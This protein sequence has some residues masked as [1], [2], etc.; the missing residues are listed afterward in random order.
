[1]HKHK[2]DWD[3]LRYALKVA[4][5][6]SIA[7]AASAL[8]VNRTTVLRRISKFEQKLDFQLFERH[9]A[10]YALAPGAEQ[11]LS[12]ALEVESTLDEL[13]RQIA[14]KAIQLQGSLRVTTTDS[15]LTGTVAPYIA[16]FRHRHP[17]IKLELVVSSHR[18]SLSR[19]E[20]DIAIRPI[21]RVPENL[22]GRKLCRIQFGVFTSRKYLKRNPATEIHQHNWLGVD[23]PLE[24]SPAGRWLAENIPDSCI[25]LSTDSF[26]ALRVMAEADMG[27]TLLP[28]N[29]GIQSRKL[30]QIFPQ[31]P[32]IE[33]DLWILTHPDLVRSARVHA[34]IEHL[35]LEMANQ[36]DSPINKE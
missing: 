16:S 22:V 12:A 10:G 4:Q 29:L 26:A 3:D 28:L 20:A 5:L 34:F 35:C 2:F 13:Q 24:Q 15:I 6:G 7:G 18:L 9:G 21:K 11:I 25:S 32:N 19:R 14:G 33:N 1:M 31:Y 36:T 17:M 8:G 23:H 27:C 30:V